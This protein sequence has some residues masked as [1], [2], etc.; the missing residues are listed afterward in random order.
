[1]L[2]ELLFFLRKSL[3]FY[4][5][6]YI[7]HLLF[8]DGFPSGQRG[9]TVNLLAPPSKVRILLHPA[10]LALTSLRCR[11]YF[12]CAK[13]KPQRGRKAAPLCT[14]LGLFFK[15]FLVV[16]EGRV[17]TC[18]CMLG[19]WMWDAV[20]IWFLYASVLDAGCCADLFFGGYGRLLYWLWIVLRPFSVCFGVGCG[21]LCRSGSCILRCWTWNVVPIYFYIL[22]FLGTGQNVHSLLLSALCG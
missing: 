4:Q 13:R 8:T 9:Q 6:L 12:F 5:M 21:T 17:L 11:S 7:I 2:W 16:D 14:P 15:E 3:Q 22:C 20:P 1:M 19:Y 10:N 18:V